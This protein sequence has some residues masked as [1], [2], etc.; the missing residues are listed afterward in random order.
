M[1]EIGFDAFA[2][3]IRKEFGQKVE[4]AEA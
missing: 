2:E 3:G 4:A 1:D